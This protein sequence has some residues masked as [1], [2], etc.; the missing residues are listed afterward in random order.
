[1]P[2]AA[3]SPQKILLIRPSALGDVCRSVPLAVSL[4]AAFPSSTLDWLVNE[5][6][7]DAVRAHPCVDRIVAFPR[8]QLGR[9]SASGRFDQS[10][11]WMNQHLRSPGY[12]LVVD[13]Q[14]LARSGLFSF[15]TRARRRIGFAGA[16]ELGWLGYTEKHRVSVTHTVDRMLGLLQA[17]GIPPIADLRLHSPPEDRAAAQRDPILGSSRYALLAPTSRWPGKLWPAD[18]FAALASELLRRG[19]DHVVVVASGNERDQCGP[20]LELAS[21]EPRIIDRIGATSVGGLMAL[22]ERAS[23]VVANDSAALHIAVGFDRPLI[24]LFGP[25]RIELVGP[26]RRERDVL[27]FLEAGDSMNHKDAAIG[28]RIMGRI[29]LDHVLDRLPK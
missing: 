25:T 6:F 20:L 12:D 22:I 5:P 4:K 18:R 2:D 16:R 7:A 3:P 21:R 17:A 27:Q 28:Q 29:T 13:A 9:A 8:K 10:L 26:Y 1:M 23:L 19:F 11:R 15:W 14:G 24:A